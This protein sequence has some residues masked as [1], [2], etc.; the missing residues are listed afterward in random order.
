MEGYGEERGRSARGDVPHLRRDAHGASLRV[1]HPVGGVREGREAAAGPKVEDSFQVP[2]AIEPCPLDALPVTL[3]DTPADVGVERRGLDAKEVA[4]LGRAQ[5]WLSVD[6]D[7]VEPSV[8]ELIAA[9]NRLQYKS[10]CA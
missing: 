8:R 3:K 6:L 7:Q 4:R 9:V 1:A 10:T 5:V 2:A